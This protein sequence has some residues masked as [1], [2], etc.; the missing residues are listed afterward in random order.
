MIISFVPLAASV[1]L[2][3]Q[4][5]ARAASC[6]E[7]SDFSFR[8]GEGEGTDIRMHR[9]A[10]AKRIRTSPW[11]TLLLAAWPQLCWRTALLFSC[12]STLWVPDGQLTGLTSISASECSMASRS[13]TAWHF[14]CLWARFLF[15]SLPGPSAF[16][17]ITRRHS[18]TSKA[19]NHG[20]AWA[21]CITLKQAGAGCGGV[22]G[23]IPVHH[24]RCS[25]TGHTQWKICGFCRISLIFCIFI[26]QKLSSVTQSM[27]HKSISHS[28]CHV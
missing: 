17:Y 2:T 23:K 20:L 7:G 1:L 5:L 12:C 24:S 8:Q 9:E 10:F 11:L 4:H 25:Y 16:S 19:L 15:F 18:K 27:T 6:Q 14:L 22:L 28:S 3:A 21:F 13:I 26:L